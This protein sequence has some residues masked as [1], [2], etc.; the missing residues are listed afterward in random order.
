MLQRNVEEL[1]TIGI[2]STISQSSHCGVSPQWPLNQQIKIEPWLGALLNSPK[3]ETKVKN[4]YAPLTH[5][6]PKGLVMLKINSHCSFCGSQY[7]VKQPWPRRCQSCQ[8]TSYLNPLPVVVVLLPVGSGVI[9]IRRNIQPQKG[10]LTLP[11]GYLDLGETW[12]QGAIR[13]LREETGISIAADTINL[14]DVQNGL[15]ATLVIFGLASPQPLEV[16]IPFS[17]TETQEVVC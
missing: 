17:S 16:Y 9:V 12:Q 14:Y 6:K 15:D 10:T 4:I 13:E 3:A 7:P 1:D 2:Y 8:N 11:G 5:Q